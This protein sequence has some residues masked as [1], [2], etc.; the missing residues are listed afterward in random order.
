MPNIYKEKSRGKVYFVNNLV[1]E[2]CPDLIYTMIAAR[3]L[4]ILGPVSSACKW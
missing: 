3:F 1:L 4:Y 2:F